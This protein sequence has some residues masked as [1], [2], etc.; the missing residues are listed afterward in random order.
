VC[1]ISG[2]RFTQETPKNIKVW[3]NASDTKEGGSKDNLLLFIAVYCCLLLFMPTLEV[4]PEK[5]GF[6]AQSA[7][8]GHTKN[9][10]MAV[11]P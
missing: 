4:R 2:E 8:C 7:N 9:A 5:C 11:P 1:N 3:T 6:S 10:L